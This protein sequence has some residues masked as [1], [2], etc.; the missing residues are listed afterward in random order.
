MAEIK[1]LR[2]VADLSLRDEIINH[3]IRH[4]AHIF[5]SGENMTDRENI[6][7]AWTPCTNQI[8]PTISAVYD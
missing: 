5:S 2:R 6:T 3:A 7:T 1:F 8:M 4:E